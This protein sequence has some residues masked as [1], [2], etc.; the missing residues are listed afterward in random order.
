MKTRA[1]PAVERMRASRSGQFIFVARGRLART[2][3]RRRSAMTRLDAY[4]P[5]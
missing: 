2:A 5:L 3:H 4:K 1:N